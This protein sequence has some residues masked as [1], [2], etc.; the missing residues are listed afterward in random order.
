MVSYWPAQTHRDFAS[1]EGASV[2]AFVPRLT[3]VVRCI[4]SSRFLHIAI[5]GW[6]R[7]WD[8][9]AG[10]RRTYR[11]LE[12]FGRD[13]HEI[14]AVRPPRAS[15]KTPPLVLTRSACTR[16]LPLSCTFSAI[17]VPNLVSRHKFRNCL[18][19]RSYRLVRAGV[20][21]LTRFAWLSEIEQRISARLPRGA[22]VLDRRDRPNRPHSCRE[23]AN[24]IPHVF[25]NFGLK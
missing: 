21:S 19:K 3:S 15:E 11:A 17:A 16:P 1:Q 22:C 5:S 25:V 10:R 9:A 13:L 2:C 14:S 6:L 12:S 18:G 23:P 8:S 24:E 7:A 4:E 20:L